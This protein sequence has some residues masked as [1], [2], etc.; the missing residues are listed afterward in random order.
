MSKRD[1]LHIAIAVLFV[2]TVIVWALVYVISLKP[3]NLKTVALET[4]LEN[5]FYIRDE[6]EPYIYSIKELGVGNF[7]SE[8][9]EYIRLY[10]IEISDGEGNNEIYLVGIWYKPHGLWNYQSQ[11]TPKKNI[12]QV[13]LSHK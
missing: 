9:G 10:E 2:I 7:K 11:T 6:D 5:F 1:K 13:D 8:K 3:T 4:A 12:K